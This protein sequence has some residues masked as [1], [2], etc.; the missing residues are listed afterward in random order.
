M[1]EKYYDQ[2]LASLELPTND[3]A[4]AP[5]PLHKQTMEDTAIIIQ[6]HGITPPEEELDEEIPDIPSHIHPSSIPTYQ[7]HDTK[8]SFSLPKVS[9]KLPHLRLPF[10][11]M[12]HTKKLTISILIL[13]LILLGISIIFTK[14]KQTKKTDGII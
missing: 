10:S 1:H 5:F 4:E 12:S 3:I 8:R 11:K 14:Q 2:E 7:P 13:L 9:L 6:Y